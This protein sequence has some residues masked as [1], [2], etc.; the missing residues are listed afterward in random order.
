VPRFDGCNLG[1][2]LGVG[3]VSMA[4]LVVKPESFLAEMQLFKDWDVIEETD[5]SS[6]S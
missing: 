2:V 1:V 6:D 3:K 4:V 5:D